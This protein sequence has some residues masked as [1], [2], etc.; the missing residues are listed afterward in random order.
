MPAPWFLASC[1]TIGR[2]RIRRGSRSSRCGPSCCTPGAA[3]S[4]NASAET[5]MRLGYTS[6]DVSGVPDGANLGLGCGNPQAI[7]ALQA[8]E[9][10]ID[11]GSGGGF[12]CFLAA[13]KVGPTG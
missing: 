4:G 11:L 3:S 13:R 6:Q 8:G 5:A 1:A 10:V 7:A 2:S 12:D 9:T